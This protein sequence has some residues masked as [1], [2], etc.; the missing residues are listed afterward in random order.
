MFSPEF[1]KGESELAT[2]Q[3]RVL[4]ECFVRYPSE[5]LHLAYWGTEFLDR[6]SVV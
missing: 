4:S 6:K 3:E 5:L 2:P 1:L